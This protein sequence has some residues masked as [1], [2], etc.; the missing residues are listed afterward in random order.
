MLKLLFILMLPVF[1]HAQSFETCEDNSFYSAVQKL[2]R[3]I[4]GLQGQV[5]A[6]NKEIER[7]VNSLPTSTDPRQLRA[8][9]RTNELIEKHQKEVLEKEERIANLVA[10]RASFM[11]LNSYFQSHKNKTY[12]NE[13]GLLEVEV[14]E[15][16]DVTTRVHRNGKVESVS[17]N[18]T[19]CVRDGR[20]Y[21]KGLR[22]PGVPTIGSMTSTRDID[23]FIYFHEGQIKLVPQG[24]NSDLAFRSFTEFTSRYGNTSFNLG[25]TTQISPS[26]AA[27][28]NSNESEVSN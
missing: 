18:V 9:Q 24:L 11:N 28:S 4:E 20:T 8:F 3:E 6:L 14:N 22:V 19:W 13:K 10:N 5:I 7:N 27:P 16:L 21:V 1:V 15:S 12:K 23:G 17:S 26:N 2:D 25:S